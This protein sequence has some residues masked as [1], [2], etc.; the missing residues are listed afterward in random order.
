[1]ATCWV[2]IVVR[3]YC[4]T[5]KI[6]AA[7]W[8]ILFLLLIP[9]TNHSSPLI[10]AAAH[11]TPDRR[12]FYFITADDRITHQLSPAL[13]F[14]R[15][16][17][18]NIALKNE[19][20][21]GGT[22][23]K[24]W[25]VWRWLPR[26]PISQ[27]LYRSS[28]RNGAKDVVVFV[29]GDVVFGGCA[30]RDFVAAYDRIVKKSGCTIVASAEAQCYAPGPP[31]WQVPR[32]A[33]YDQPPFPQREKDF[34][35]LPFV[36]R[37][38]PK[39]KLAQERC[40]VQESGGAPFPAGCKR[41]AF[42]NSGAYAGPI[43]DVH[44][45]VSW[46]LWRAMWDLVPGFW[47]WLYNGM[48]YFLIPNDQTTMHTYMHE[49]PERV[50]LDYNA[51]LFVSGWGLDPSKMFDI[52]KKGVKL[53]VGGEV[54]SLSK[55]QQQQRPMCFL[56][57]NSGT[58]NWW[59]YFATNKIKEKGAEWHALHHNNTSGL[60]GGYKKKPP[61]ERP[62][63]TIGEWLGLEAG[64]VLVL[65]TGVVAL[66]G[67]VLFIVIQCSHLVAAMSGRYEAAPL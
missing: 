25:K 64:E 16:H 12:T 51:E 43:D 32:C 11:R 66:I 19:F 10:N 6:I 53:N 20:F 40:F 46:M 21:R 9:N 22:L 17:L 39:H 56:H 58:A 67:F 48:R 49:H 34:K 36:P 35:T 33:R 61:P 31:P 30:L 55:P 52:S 24:I 29:D 2:P 18:H 47:H 54:Q 8:L 57:D 50:V 27:R 59:P 60:S 65:V 63:M 62:K 13:P 14:T 37:T 28:P 5:L 26:T 7:A 23:W 42:L 38:D 45:M 44:K 41:Y 15:L 4:L 1:M 3:F